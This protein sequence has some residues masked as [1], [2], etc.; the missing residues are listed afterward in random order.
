MRMGFL[1]LWWFVWAG[2]AEEPMALLSDN[3]S[4]GGKTKLFPAGTPVIRTGASYSWVTAGPFATDKG[5]VSSTEKPGIKCLFDGGDWW[6]SQSYGEWDGGAWATVRI[7]LH[8]DYLIGK[9][10]VWANRHPQRDTERA[11]ILFSADGKEFT[12][13]GFAQNSADPPADE[14]KG[15]PKKFV[16]HSK[17]FDKPVLARY[18]ELRMH[19][20][21]HQQ[22]LSEIAIWGWDRNPDAAPGS[23]G[24]YLQ[25]SDKPTV[26]FALKPIQDGAVLVLWPDAAKSLPGVSAWKVYVAPRAFRRVDGEGVTLCRSF[27]GKATSGAAYPF[28]PGATVHLAVAAVYGKDE[29][30]VV[31]SQPIRLRTPFECG[32]FGEMIAI[33]HFLGGGAFSRSAA[34]EEFSLELLAQTPV[35]ETRW[36][37]MF[38]STVERFL[39]R[40]IGMITWPTLGEDSVKNNVRNANSLGLY[41]FTKGNEPELNGVSPAAYATALQ[42]QYAQAKRLSPWNT[43]AAPTCNLNVSALKWLDDFYAAG[44]K[45]AFDVL[46]LHTYCGAPENLYE[47]IAKVRTLMAKYGDEQKPLISTEFGYADCP[48]GRNR[49]SPLQK[50][51]YLVRGLVIHY[52]LGFRRVYVY[53][54]ADIGTDPYNN[55]HHFGL[56]DFDLQKKPAFHAVRTLGEQLGPCGLLG[57][58]DG[59]PAPSR[60]Y[61]FK[62]PAP[63]T[64]VAVVWNPDGESAGKFCTDAGEVTI[65][66]LLGDS[67]QLIVEPGKSFTLPYGPSPL[68]IR[69]P[70]PIRMESTTR[71]A[72]AAASTRTGQLDFALGADSLIAGEG[73]ENG[74]LELVLGNGWAEAVSCTVTIKDGEGRTVGTRAM[75]LPGHGQWREKMSFALGMAADLA[76][77][78][79]TVFLSYQTSFSSYSAVRQ[80]HVRRLTP[81][82]A[83]P[84]CTTRRFQGLDRPLYVLANNALE[85]TFD[86]V[87]GGR[88]LELIE[89]SSRTNQ[90]RL[91]YDKLPVLTSFD[92]AYAVWFRVNGNLRNS[93][94]TVESRKAQLQLAASEPKSGAK[95]A[96][97]WTLDEERPRLRLDVR[98]ANP[99]AAAIKGTFYMHPEYHVAG[100]AEATSDELSF[101]TA[102]GELTLPF[103]PDLGERKLPPLTEAWWRA[104]DTRSG[105]VLRQTF[106][107]AWLTPKIWFG[108][109]AYNVEMT[110]EYELLPQQ[111]WQ[112]WLTWELSRTTGVATATQEEGKH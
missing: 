15:E 73:A 108:G 99:G 71:L 89:R 34:W 29:Y 42:E 26:A 46:D 68:Y 22:Q 47:S 82:T 88:L 18:V 106:S 21:R 84:T 50:A 87:Q 111:E 31:E 20:L 56:L 39:G 7:D 5:T 70:K 16:R 10:D 48:A 33:N 45:A 17:A 105:M 40:G 35:R 4:P 101:P 110:H 43:I 27:P 76:L 92:H 25:A 28:T 102:A 95:V 112:G 98:L 104:R 54:F 63:E 93:A 96:L 90:I 52:A 64:H 97:L 78:R 80:V 86:P 55:E 75:A 109:D 23:A 19:K 51:Q 79:Y 62:S 8:K 2:V 12:Q 77:A 13:H 44:A 14:G 3:I 11:D 57:P 72:N 30:P 67:R 38:P 94:W 83:G 69:S 85:A 32:N 49:I 53:S 59:C 6:Q 61:L 91:D 65:V 1:L 9:V 103:W 58:L 66:E 107:D 41:S 37:F 60:G 74:E 81:V 24:A 100:G 36:W